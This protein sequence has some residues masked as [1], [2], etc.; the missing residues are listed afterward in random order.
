MSTSKFPKF[1]PDEKTLNNYLELMDVAFN[2]TEITDDAEKVNIILTH[3]STRYF[4]NL[5]AFFA[6]NSPSALS[7]ENLESNLIAFLIHL[8]R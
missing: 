3:I 6:P 4:Y 5:L 7:L 8:I 1:V 2:A